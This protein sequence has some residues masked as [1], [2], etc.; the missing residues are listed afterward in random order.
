MGSW[1]LSSACHVPLTVIPVTF[2]GLMDGHAEPRQIPAWR[3]LSQI[4]KERM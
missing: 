3:I 4:L 1:K 2:S